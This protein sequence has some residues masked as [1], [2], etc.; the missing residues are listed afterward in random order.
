MVTAHSAEGSE[1]V[2]EVG[3]NENMAPYNRYVQDQT[4]QASI[5]RGRWTNTVQETARRN[6]ATIQRYFGSAITG[7]IQQVTNGND[8]GNRAVGQPVYG[9][10]SRS[11][12]G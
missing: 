8:A 5:H 12:H 4:Q 9:S 2:G 1:L 6:R 3:S 10:D 7:R 11:R